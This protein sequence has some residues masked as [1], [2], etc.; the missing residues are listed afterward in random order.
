MTWTSPAAES[1]HVT[2]T[3]ASFSEDGTESWSII[4]KDREGKVLSESM[5]KNTRRK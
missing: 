5:G 4:D 1:G 2:L 3:K